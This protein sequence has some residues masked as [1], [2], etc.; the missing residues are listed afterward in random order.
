MSLHRTELYSSGIFPGHLKALVVRKESPAQLDNPAQSG[1][2]V[3]PRF[4]HLQPAHQV[5]NFT[6]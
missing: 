4:P 6:P 1:I 3:A 5:I 2:D